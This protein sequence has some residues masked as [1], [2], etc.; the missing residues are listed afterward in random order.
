MYVATTEMFV[1]A[2]QALMMYPGLTTGSAKL[3]EKYGT[4]EQQE[5]YMNNMYAGQWAGTMCLTEPRRA[6]TLERYGPKR[7]ETPTEPSHIT[8]ARSLF[9]QA[10]TILQK[11]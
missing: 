2:N 5:L 3:I 8:E 9:P 11:T 7:S 1:A 10:I 4:E 6:A